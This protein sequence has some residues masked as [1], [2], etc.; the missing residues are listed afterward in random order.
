MNT[1]QN[2]VGRGFWLRWVLATIAGFIIGALLGVYVA[3][4]LFDGDGSDAT[5]GI[6][7]GIVM[8]GTGGC[9]QWLVLREKIARAGWWVLAS[10]LGFA[11]T[12]GILGVIGIGESNESY[13]MAGILFAVVFEVAG[14]I[15]QWLVLRRAEIA[16]AGLW[17]LASILGSL[18]AA[19]GFPISYTIGADGNY[20]LSGLVFGLFL[21]VGLGA[22]CGA[23][24]VWLQRQSPSSSIKGL[25]TAH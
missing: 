1:N 4:G 21:G 19:I 14:G 3:Y 24:L 9:L 6:T 17:M 10:A 25:A 16:H 12:L 11:I 5:I 8:G 15:L 23:M 7:A 2:N 13:V 18:V 22:I 20:A